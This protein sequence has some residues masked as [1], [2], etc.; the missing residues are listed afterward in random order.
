MKVFCFT[1]ISIYFI[2]KYFIRTFKKELIVSYV[3]GGINMKDLGA[4][5][6]D[7]KRVAD[8]VIPRGFFLPL[9]ISNI[10]HQSPK[11]DCQH[12]LA[13]PQCQSPSP[14]PFLTV[15]DLGHQELVHVLILIPRKAFLH[16]SFL[17]G[18][19]LPFCVFIST[20]FLQEFFISYPSYLKQHHKGVL[21]SSSRA[22]PSLSIL[23]N[24]VH[25]GAVWFY[26]KLSGRGF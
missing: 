21:Q 19:L 5:L 16:Q 12:H 1:F 3:C 14:R 23:K 6:Q 8:C 26:G 13:G 10:G 7:L 9:S 2:L 17:L 4:G 11:D 18:V 24:N 25:I 20:H 15:S 22:S